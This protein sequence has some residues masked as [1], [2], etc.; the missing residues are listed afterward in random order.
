[1]YTGLPEGNPTGGVQQAKSRF[2]DSRQGEVRSSDLP[3]LSRLK[4]DIG[5]LIGGEVGPLF[6]EDS[7]PVTLCCL[8]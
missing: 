4:P 7:L 5:P 8:H 2:V 1:M 6:W 3:D